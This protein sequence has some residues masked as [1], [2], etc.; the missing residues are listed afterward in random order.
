ML[1]RFRNILFLL[2]VF[3]ASSFAVDRNAFTFTNYDLE[4]RVDP[5]GQAMSA[6]GKVTVRNDSDKPQSNLVLQVSSSLEWRM[7]ELDG[8]PLEYVADS[9]TTDIDHS[10]QVTEAVVRLPAPV[11]PKASLVLDVGYSGTIVRDATRLTRMQVPQDQAFASDW[12]RISSEF[13]GIRGIGH[14]T[15]YPIAVDPANVGENTLFPRIAQWQAREAQT[16][17]KTRFCWI[18]DEEHSFEVVANGNFEGMGGGDLGGQGNRS[19]CTSFTFANLQQTVPTFAIAPF[20]MLTR[21]TISLYYLTGHDQQASEMAAAAEK[22]QP[23]LQD[24]FG[25]PAKKIEVIQLPEAN[26]AAFDS[27]SMLFTPLGKDKKE[28]EVAM[29]HQTVRV[30]F[31]SNRPWIAE[32]LA[33]FGSMLAVE[34]IYGRR[35]AIDYVNANLPVLIAAENENAAAAKPSGDAAQSLVS[36]TDD[37]YYRT[38]A[39][40]VWSMLRDMIGDKALQAIIKNYRAADDKD[41]TYVQRLIAA[42]DKRD[43]EWFFDDWVYRDRGLPRLKIEAAVPRQTLENSSVTA[44]TVE[45]S[46]GAGVEIPIT[47]RGEGGE[48]TSRTIVPAHQKV[49]TRLTLPGKPTEVSIN[50]GS[51]PI[52]DTSDDKMELK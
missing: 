4:I 48:Q 38:K 28:N 45:N 19:G 50:D 12:D 41:P 31:T 3:S 30:S 18:T 9:Q 6:R 32:G 14:V 35:A 46:G 29:A 22:V 51:V 49:T 24:W 8:K 1:S 42:Q 37:I 2:I 20:E 43:L 39:V 11:A 27:G 40:W 36:T 5:E 17:M 21:P 16:T 13:T 52:M 26:D 25:K 7:I 34:Q 47:V 15:W 44:V 10:G 33:G 23:L